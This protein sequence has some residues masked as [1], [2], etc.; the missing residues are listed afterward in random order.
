MDNMPTVSTLYVSQ[1]L[2]SPAEEGNYAV[3]SAEGP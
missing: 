3:L 2:S 1:C